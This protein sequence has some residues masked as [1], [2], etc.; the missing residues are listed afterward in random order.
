VQLHFPQKNGVGSFFLTP[1]APIAKL[2]ALER[3]PRAV[4]DGLVDHARNQGNNRAAVFADDDDHLALL[5][6]LASTK[7]LPLPPPRRLLG[8]KDMQCKPSRY[9]AERTTSI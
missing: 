5:Q 3:L 6:A 7:K 4:E 1:A 2:P 9:R 8:R